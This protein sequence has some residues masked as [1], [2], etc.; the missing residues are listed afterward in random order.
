LRTADGSFLA[1][2]SFNAFNPEKSVYVSALAV[3][4][5]ASA[6]MGRVGMLS[7]PQ[8]TISSARNAPA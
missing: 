7:S 2:A 4:A 1:A 6:G 3:A 8:I 5:E